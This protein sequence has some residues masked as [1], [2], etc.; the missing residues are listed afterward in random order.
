MSGAR[1]HALLD[2]ADRIGRF[3]ETAL[4]TILLTGLVAIGFAQIVL[5]N[6]F[7]T[8]LSWA[9]EGGQMLVLWIAVVGAVAATRDRRHIAIDLAGRLLPAGLDRWVRVLVHLFAT[10]VAGSF[11]WYAGRFVLDSKNFGDLV[12][13]ALPAWAFQSVIPIG[14][15]LIAYRFGVR[16]IRRIVVGDP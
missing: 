7:A 15:A 11:A 2:A 4:L 1:R 13:G 10:I 12:F 3:I 8:S 6:G 5:R 16:A 14:F 9:D